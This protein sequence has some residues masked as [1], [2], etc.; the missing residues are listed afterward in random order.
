MHFYQLY[1][2]YNFKVLFSSNLILFAII[3]PFESVTCRTSSVNSPK[4][5]SFLL[6]K[7]SSILSQSYLVKLVLAKTN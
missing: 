7:L 3:Y 1:L 6:Y 2:A 4:K 5:L